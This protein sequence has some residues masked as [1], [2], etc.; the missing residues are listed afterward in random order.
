MT[1]H[2]RKRFWFESALGLICLAAL[3]LT[4][5]SSNWIET[6]TGLDPDGGTGAAEWAIVVA[7]M[8]LTIAAVGLACRELR[9]AAALR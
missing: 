9:R 8:A 4:A 1:H 2:L 5:T 6:F 3:L 7:L